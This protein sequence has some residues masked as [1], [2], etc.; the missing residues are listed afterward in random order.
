MLF[1]SS[2]IYAFESHYREK[3]HL[4]HCMCCQ[5]PEFC[6]HSLLDSQCHIRTQLLSSHPPLLAG[7]DW[8]STERG[9]W[10]HPVQH[11]VPSY[12]CALTWQPEL[13]EMT[14][15]SP[16]NTLA[17]CSQTT[18]ININNK[19]SLCPRVTESSLTKSATFFHTFQLCLSAR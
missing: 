19:Q 18:N 2:Y 7:V 5:Q 17:S 11:L 6:S 9:S 12:G 1:K 14:F 16:T 10:H 4:K 3:R 15:I 13:H 8:H